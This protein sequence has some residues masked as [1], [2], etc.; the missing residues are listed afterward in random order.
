MD[1]CA[2]VYQ[3]SEEVKK[4]FLIRNYIVAGRLR[5]CTIPAMIKNGQR[6]FQQTHFVIGGTLVSDPA[7]YRASKLVTR[8]TAMFGGRLSAQRSGLT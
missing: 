7:S 2:A 5:A 3:E 4:T 1:D 6:T 8:Y